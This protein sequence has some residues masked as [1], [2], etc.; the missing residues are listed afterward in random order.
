MY[1]IPMSKAGEPHNAANINVG[2]VA[3]WS[4]DDM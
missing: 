3:A 2:F 4:G 1:M